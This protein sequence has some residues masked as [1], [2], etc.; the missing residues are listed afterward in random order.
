MKINQFAVAT[1]STLLIG[2][3]L[4]AQQPLPG[5]T[6]QSQTQQRPAQQGQIQPGQV[7]PGQV[8]AVQPA[9][10]QRAV[11]GSPLS[12]DQT[13]AKLLEIAN[14]EQV[15]IARYAQENLTHDAVKAFAA[16]MEK[17]HQTYVDALKAVSSKGQPA[18]TAGI[19]SSQRDDSTASNPGSPRADSLASRTASQG[20]GQDA[21][22]VDFLQL[23]QEIS[24]QCLKDS[25][26]WLSEKDGIEIDKCFVGMQVAKHAAMKSSLTVLERHASSDLQSLIQKGIKKN[27]E[28]MKVAVSLME[29]LADIDSS[30]AVKT[31]TN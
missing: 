1:L 18:T 23:H 25:K 19:T 20:T 31:S 12:K 26:E 11:A 9:S 22:S 5:Q 13:F 24:E 29:K 10:G 30:K 16:T 15:A 4:V 14:K 28:H 3:S 8:Q 2:G 27:D 7:Q 21:S 17:E 6:Q